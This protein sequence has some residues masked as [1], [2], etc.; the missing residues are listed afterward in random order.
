M[1]TIKIMNPEAI[2]LQQREIDN[3]IHKTFP[4]SVY[5]KKASTDGVI[6]PELYVKEP[7]KIM[8]VMKE[9]NNKDGYCQKQLFNDIIIE[10]EECQST[11]GLRKNWHMTLDPVIY[12]SNMILMGLI[13]YENHDLSYISDDYRIVKVLQRISYIN[14]KKIPGGA[15]SNNN[16]LLEFYEKGKEI[17]FKQLEVANPD[18]V[19]CGNTLRFLKKDLQLNVHKHTEFPIEYSTNSDRLYINIY[20]PMYLSLK[21][22]NYRGKYYNSI[23]QIIKDWLPESKK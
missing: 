21:P 5:G 23:I 20:H 14:I 22:E 8:W 3:L 17:F 10:I 15:T 12:L 16:E 13:N 6:Q 11:K 9:I 18:I 1:K 4:K 19:I 7:A 2:H